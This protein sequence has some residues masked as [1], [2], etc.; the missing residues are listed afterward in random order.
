MNRMIAKHLLS[1]FAKAYDYDTEYLEKMADVSP[2]A[3]YRYLLCTPLGTYCRHAPPESYLIAKLIA[4]KHFDC[5]PCLELVLN[6]ARQAKID[7]ELLYA[8]LIGDENR[9]PENMVIARR[10]ALAVIE[11]DASALWSSEEWIVE[12]WDE[13][14]LTDMALAVAF[15]A[16]YPLLRRGLGHAHSCQPVVHK[17]ESLIKSGTN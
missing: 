9:L 1:G 11:Q 15:A 16:F 13:A 7:D 14:A 10:Y 2:G 3:F 12:H 5:G 4:T 6:M 17:L 8:A